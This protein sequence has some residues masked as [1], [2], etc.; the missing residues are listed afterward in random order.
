MPSLWCFITVGSGDSC[1]PPLTSQH[2]H[3]SALP[4]PLSLKYI[5]HVS[6]SRHVVARSP[7]PL[8]GITAQ[9]PNY[10]LWFYSSLFMASSP[11][12]SQITLPPSTTASQCLWSQ[13]ET[14]CRT[15]D[16]PPSA[17]PASV[18]NLVLY[19]TPHTPCPG[20]TY[21]RVVHPDGTC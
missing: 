21:F 16:M 7:S 15:L 12:M 13:I 1:T 4:W 11:H 5:P 20:H 19:P 14:P 10:S 3:P 18:S 17:G 8:T 2:S 9:L 6:T